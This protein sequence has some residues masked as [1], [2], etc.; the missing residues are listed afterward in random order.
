MLGTFC[1]F[2]ENI[3]WIGSTIILKVEMTEKLRIPFQ[4]QAVIW[5]PLK[6]LVEKRKECG[7][8]WDVGFGWKRAFFWGS[9]LWLWRASSTALASPLELLFV[10][11]HM[12]VAHSECSVNGSSPATASEWSFLNQRLHF[13]QQNE[14]CPNSLFR[15]IFPTHCMWLCSQQGMRKCQN[16]LSLPAG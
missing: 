1:S 10:Q 3:L 16:L 12:C 8:D 13:A 2:L 11:Q 14:K 6:W 5:L 4:T 7:L 15:L 9:A